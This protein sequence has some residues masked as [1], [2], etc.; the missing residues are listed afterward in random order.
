MDRDMRCSIFSFGLYVAHHTVVH[1]A[2]TERQRKR[3]QEAGW[4]TLRQAGIIIIDIIIIIIIIILDGLDSRASAHHDVTI[5]YSQ[6]A[7]SLPPLSSWSIAAF[8]FYMVAHI[9]IPWQNLF[10]FLT[11]TG[12]H[13]NFPLPFSYFTSDTPPTP[14][15]K[16]TLT[17]HFLIH[18]SRLYDC[19]L[20]LLSFWLATNFGNLE[21]QLPWSWLPHDIWDCT[22]LIT[23]VPFPRHVGRRKPS[24]RH[25]AK[26][27]GRLVLVLEPFPGD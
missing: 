16:E 9:A 26:R 23:L 21:Y 25:Q 15:F 10:S 14:C 19:V 22:W 13:S 8:V 12:S 2:W 11:H 5:V 18:T 4:R 27:E 1:R 24:Y 20:L 3:W 17:T 7:L 6:F